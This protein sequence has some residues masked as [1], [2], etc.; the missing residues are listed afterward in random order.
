MLFKAL[1]FIA[2]LWNVSFMWVNF[3]KKSS[4][5]WSFDCI[6]DQTNSLTNMLVGLSGIYPLFQVAFFLPGDL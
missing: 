3:E 2:L 1:L 4:C 6:C 5:N